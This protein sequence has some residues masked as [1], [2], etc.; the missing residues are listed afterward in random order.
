MKLF[1][2]TKDTIKLSALSKSASSVVDKDLQVKIDAIKQRLIKQYGYNEQSAT[3]V[4]EYVAYIFARGQVT[5]D[6]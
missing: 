6:E 5:E 3:D 2:D 4:L 1:E